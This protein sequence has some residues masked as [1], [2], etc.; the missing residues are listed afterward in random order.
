MSLQVSKYLSFSVQLC[1]KSIYVT[2]ISLICLAYLLNFQLNHPSTHWL[3]KPKQTPRQAITS[4]IQS[5]FLLAIGH[6]GFVF[7]LKITLPFIVL[8]C[9]IIDT[10]MDTYIIDHKT[11]S[12]HA[13]QRHCCK[14]NLRST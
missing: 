2:L 4:K 5:R 13:R 3:Y 10:A 12:Y 7:Y 1:H 6:P 11:T 9:V 14:I 8:L